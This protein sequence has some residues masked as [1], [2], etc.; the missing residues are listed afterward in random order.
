VP[1]SPKTSYE[2]RYQIIRN[3]QR[4]G[5]IEAEFHGPA[6]YGLD[7][8]SLVDFVDPGEPRTMEHLDAALYAAG[9]EVMP[10][11]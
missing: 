10:D 2:Y 5:W 8:P 4:V 7:D 11:E 3:G 9:F 6:V 1:Q